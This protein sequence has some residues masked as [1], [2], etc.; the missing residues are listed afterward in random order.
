M[1][2]KEYPKIQNWKKY[3]SV[4]TRLDI[5]AEN[6]DKN[7]CINCGKTTWLEAHH[8]I[9]EIEKLDNLMTLC[10]SCH[11]KEHNFSGCF[12]KGFDKRR[13]NL[14]KSFEGKYYNRYLKQWKPISNL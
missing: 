3:K 4:R 1:N 6:R 2:I 7:Q 14:Q 12:K 13:N 9:P 8:K 11:K 10:H 5:E